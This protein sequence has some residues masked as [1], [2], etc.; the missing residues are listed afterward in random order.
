VSILVDR[1]ALAMI[2]GMS[3]KTVRKCARARGQTGTPGPGLRAGA[4]T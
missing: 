4:A 1:R 3:M 2:D